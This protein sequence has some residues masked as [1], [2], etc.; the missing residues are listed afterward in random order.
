VSEVVNTPAAEA[1]LLALGFVAGSTYSEYPL[2]V[3]NDAGDGVVA[4][5]LAAQAELEKRGFR[6]MGH[7]DQTAF[8]HAKTRG[9]PSQYEPIA[10]PKWLEAPG[11][12][13]VL[14]ADA[15]AEDRVRRSWGEPE[16][17]APPLSEEPEP[18]PSLSEDFKAFLAWKES[19]ANRRPRSPAAK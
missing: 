2:M 12:E 4:V 9:V 6:R 7:A 19:L 13:P 11:H 8:E 17:A 10:Y 14:V 18:A 16:P 3:Y 5:S 15:A 1:A